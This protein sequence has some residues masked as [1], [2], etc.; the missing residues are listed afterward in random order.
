MTGSL[1]V[2]PAVCMA[3]AVLVLAYGFIRDRQNGGGS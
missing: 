3:L 1:W 2:V